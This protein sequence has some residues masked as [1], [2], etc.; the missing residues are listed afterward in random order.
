MPESVVNITP[1]AAKHLLSVMV[2]DPAKH[3]LRLAVEKSGCSGLRYVNDLVETRQPDDLDIPAP[4]G[5]QAVIDPNAVQYLKGMTLD[6]L[7]I[8]L[9]QTKLSYINP[10]AQA[11]CGCGESFSVD[12]RDTDD[13]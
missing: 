4:E 2:R 11:A 9:G 13:E 10:N 5:L 12:A 7:Q 1:A 8:G 6:L 3:M